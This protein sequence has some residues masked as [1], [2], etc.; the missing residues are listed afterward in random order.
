MRRNFYRSINQFGSNE[1][2]Q[3]N[4]PL[5]YCIFDD[6]NKNFE[7]GGSNIYKYS[8]I[9]RPCQEYMAEYCSKKWDGFCDLAT[10][11]ESGYL[12][13]VN[14]INNTSPIGNLLQQKY[15]LKNGDVLLR[16]A[17]SKKYLTEMRDCVL[18][19]E[20]FDP[21]V[22]ASPNIHYWV[23]AENSVSG[24]I[25]IPTYEVNPA[26]IDEDPIMNKILGKPYI[27]LGLLTNI[28]NT[29]KRKGTLDQ[30]QGTKLGKFFSDNPEQFN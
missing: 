5:T 30:L 9:S 29:A 26:I 18:K 12:P 28:Y 17:A 2:S 21:L 15:D 1:L 8:S 23:P 6:P 10:T 3:V 25:C 22:A 16:N 4:D 27:A 20:P 24:G 19:S 14:T 11:V 13:Q 7:H